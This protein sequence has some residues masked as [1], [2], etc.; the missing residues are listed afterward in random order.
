MFGYDAGES[1]KSGL[2]HSETGHT[3]GFVPSLFGS[4]NSLRQ[5]DPL[6]QNWFRRFDIQHEL[7]VV[8]TP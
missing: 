3:Q 1:L 8:L 5:M 7:Y 2:K 4:A 6:G